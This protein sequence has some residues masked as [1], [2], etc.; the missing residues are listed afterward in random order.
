MHHLRY[1]LK[2]AKCLHFSKAAA[3]LSITQP[4]LSQQILLLEQELGF[5]LFERKTR[6]VSLTKAGE[7]F[8]AYADRVIIEFERLQEAMRRQSET[9]KGSLRVG[10]LLNMARLD[11]NMQAWAFQSQHP[12][13]Q[14]TI[15]EM[16]GSYELIK[17]LESE[18]FDVVF[19]IP[20][21]DM[22]FD[23]SVKLCTILP[24]RVVAAVP[25]GHRLA[26]YKVLAL[27][28]LAGENLIFPVKAHSLYSSLLAACRS[29]GF[30]PQI[31]ALNSKSDTG[32]ELSRKGIGI[33]LLSSPF[34]DDSMRAGVS[35]IAVEPEIPRHISLAY[36]KQTTNL[37]AVELFRDFIFINNQG[38]SD[39]HSFATF[40]VV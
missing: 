13:I 3:E 36:S 27:R 22:R 15:T 33:A 28:E 5:R 7:E 12:E 19:C 38:A 29:S 40:S 14:V 2:L 24:G 11:V 17:Q 25:Q 21:K 32:V 4:S 37:A 10:T 39:C 8:V 16:L 23:K 20:S 34:V 9:R 31:V 26:G 1:V 30:E 35:I 18:V 6:S